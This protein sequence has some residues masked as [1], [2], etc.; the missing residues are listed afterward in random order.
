MNE[1]GYSVIWS[2]QT[3][4]ASLNEFEY[5]YII[6]TGLNVHFVQSWRTDVIVSNKC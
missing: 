1:C 3:L 5:M 6:K 4:N 2:T